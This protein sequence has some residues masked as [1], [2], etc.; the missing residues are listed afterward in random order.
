[1]IQNVGLSDPGTKI[2]MQPATTA[3]TVG[4]QSLA[5]GL[6]RCFFAE[7]APWNPGTLEPLL[8]LDCKAG[9]LA[10]RLAL[11]KY[12]TSWIKFNIPKIFNG[13]SR[14]LDHIRSYPS[15]SILIYR[16]LQ[17]PTNFPRLLRGNRRHLFFGGGGIRPT[18]VPWRDFGLHSIFLYDNDLILV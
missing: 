6:V 18:H 11:Q 5:L 16:Y 17:G 4:F 1:M 10:H 2:G 14:P 12:K 9:F 3:V 15:L 7:T 8:L 13:S